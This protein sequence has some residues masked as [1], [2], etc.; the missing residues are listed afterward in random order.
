MW[1]LLQ[2][3]TKKKFGLIKYSSINRAFVFLSSDVMK[4]NS[5][6][7]CINSPC[8]CLKHAEQLHLFSYFKERWNNIN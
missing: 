7:G 4:G 5:P 1:L 2:L 6:T 3:M 8:V